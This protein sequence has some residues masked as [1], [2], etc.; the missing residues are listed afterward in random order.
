MAF[1]AFFA[2]MGLTVFIVP[3]GWTDFM[4]LFGEFESAAFAMVSPK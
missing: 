4:A 1:I 3:L 2:F